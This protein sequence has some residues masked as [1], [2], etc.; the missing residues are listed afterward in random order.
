MATHLCAEPALQRRFHDRGLDRRLGQRASVKFA[1]RARYRV[2]SVGTNQL[3]ML[4]PSLPRM[5]KE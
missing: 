2:E 5:L 3:H 1:L 4:W